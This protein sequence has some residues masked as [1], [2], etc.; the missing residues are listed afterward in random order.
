MV[1][2]P[3]CVFAPN[4]IAE[5]VRLVEKAPVENPFVQPCAVKAEA[6]G[7]LDVAAERIAVRRGIDAVRIIA[8]IENE[9][10]KD[11][12][13]LIFRQVPSSSIFR[14]PK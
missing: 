8:L 2:A 6:L 14:M 4:K 5:S 11:R 10:L 9:P 7:K 1:E 12:L 13:P 3:V